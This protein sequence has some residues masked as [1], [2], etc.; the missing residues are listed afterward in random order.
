MRFAAGLFSYAVQREPVL[1]TTAYILVLIIGV[2]LLLEE[3]AGVHISDWLRFGIS[4]SAILLSLAY[5]HSRV[6]QTFKPVLVWLAQGCANFNEV[7]DWAL[8]PFI[9]LF[10][11]V[12]RLALAASGRTQAV[13]VVRAQEETPPH[14]S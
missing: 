8:V 9:G 1:K 7:F 5:A 13:E 2:E 6:L 11:L 12:Q 14:H 4:I 10:H 3:F